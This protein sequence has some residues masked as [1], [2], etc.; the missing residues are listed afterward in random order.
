MQTN[1]AVE[2]NKNT[3]WSKIPWNQS[4]RKGAGLWRKVVA[5]EL[6]LKFEMKVRTST[7]RLRLVEKFIPK[8]D[9]CHKTNEP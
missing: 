3:I 4:G 5:E 7:G 2:Q 6:C 9:T 1:P 8:S